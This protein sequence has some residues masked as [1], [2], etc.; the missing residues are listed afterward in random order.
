MARQRLFV[1][2][3]AEPRRPRQLEA[4]VGELELGIDQ[5]A[6]IEH[7]IVGEELDELAVG[8]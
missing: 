1:E 8:R 4:P 2:I 3:E 7:L 6:E 5:V